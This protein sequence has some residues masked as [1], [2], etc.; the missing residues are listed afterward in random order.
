[1]HDLR[2]TPL[3]SSLQMSAMAIYRHLT[4]GFLAG[5]QRHMLQKQH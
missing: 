3:P 2:A 5:C 1:M 4:D